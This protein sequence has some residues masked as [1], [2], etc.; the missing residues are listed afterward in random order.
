MQNSMIKCYVR[1]GFRE[2][3]P[4]INL[5]T[6]T[7][8]QR[9]FI[10]KNTS[11]KTVVFE[12]EHG[13]AAKKGSTE[14]N[15][16]ATLFFCFDDIFSK[17]EIRRISFQKKDLWT[18]TVESKEENGKVLHYL[19]IAPRRI[20]RLENEEEVEIIFRIPAMRKDQ[21]SQISVEIENL[22]IDDD[23]T[24]L[25]AD[26]TTFYFSFR[27]WEKLKRLKLKSGIVGD[28]SVYVSE[29]GSIKNKFTVFLFN[30]MGEELD[31]GNKP[32]T[33]LRLSFGDSFKYTDIELVDGSP[34]STGVFLEFPL[35][36]IW[37]ENAVKELK[38]T[39]TME[40]ANGVLKTNGELVTYLKIEVLEVNGFHDVTFYVP[41]K[42]MLQKQIGSESFPIQ[43]DNETIHFK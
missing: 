24:I 32:E 43:I 34:D 2:K 17:E 4:W 39:C 6:S 14:I 13:V 42:L 15:R 33:K 11:G 27:G 37:K 40:K 23:N 12:S 28:D 8:T 18:S 35:K 9:I 41:I 36:G 21:F 7:Y 5:K 19:A 1:Q 22:K 25:D 38:F 31:L 29:Q 16:S 3:K 10:I 26:E 20:L 30:E